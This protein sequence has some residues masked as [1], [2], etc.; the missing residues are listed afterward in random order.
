MAVFAVA[1]VASASLAGALAALCL[2]LVKRSAHLNSLGR[3]LL[4]AESRRRLVARAER[5]QK[6]GSDRPEAAIAVVSGAFSPVHREHILAVAEGVEAISH[7]AGLPV[8]AVVLCPSHS[9]YLRWKYAIGAHVGGQKDLRGAFIP[10]SGRL[11]C[12]RLALE[13]QEALWEAEKSGSGETE[14]VWLPVSWE[15]SPPDWGR[16]IDLLLTTFVSPAGFLRRL[17]SRAQCFLEDVLRREG[18]EVKL[19]PFFVCGDDV[20]QKMGLDLSPF[21]LVVLQRGGS[22]NSSDD[23]TEAAVQRSGSLQDGNL[24]LRVS[25]PSLGYSSTEFRRAVISGND[26]LCRTITYPSVVAW[27][28][29]Q[30]V[31]DRMR[32]GR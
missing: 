14:P 18:A 30:G 7:E 32:G 29:R 3:N 9:G 11:E 21:S 23:T 15:G 31:L 22:D 4:D 5:V 2:F 26:E 16:V 8:I 28:D 12:I 6:Q 24:V 19:H 1:A 13:A 25:R 20:D 10:L 17:L 27:L